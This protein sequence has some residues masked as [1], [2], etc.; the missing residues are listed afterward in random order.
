MLRNID[1]I[2]QGPLLS[3]LEAVKPGGWIAITSVAAPGTADT[4]TVD[5]P[6]DRM[7]PAL[8]QAVPLSSQAEP[9]IGWLADAA[10]DDALDAFFAVQG[11]ARDAER[12]SFEM[13][14]L[15]EV[16]SEVWDNVELTLVVDSP[17]EFTFFACTGGSQHELVELLA[18]PERQ[19]A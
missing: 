10:D 16:P 6:L 14:R 9:I 11:S 4:I 13:G 7:A 18:V 15:L 1:P 2:I 19:A 3:A 17:A 12:R 5:A 8:F